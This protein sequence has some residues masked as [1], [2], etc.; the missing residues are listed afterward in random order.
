MTHFWKSCLLLLFVTTGQLSAQQKIKISS[1]NH[2]LRDFINKDYS[3]TLYTYQDEH[4]LKMDHNAFWAKLGSEAYALRVIS[5]KGKQT[6]KQLEPRPHHK[7]I[8][9][10]VNFDSL[11]YSLITK[12]AKDYKGK[13]VALMIFWAA[14]SGCMMLTEDVK[15]IEKDY[16]D[17]VFV[18][19]T[20]NWKGLK[21]YGEKHQVG[22]IIILP[23]TYDADVV[24]YYHSGA[25]NTLFIDENSEIKAITTGARLDFIMKA[26][27]E[28]LQKL[29]K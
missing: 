7:L 14:S 17:I 26:F 10:K 6:I 5:E 24:K 28:K 18:H 19:L 1:G 9:T 29:Q 8:G 15:L 13:K 2:S 20:T 16:P 25:P 21:A 11:D 12:T 23:E 22:D 4:G 27:K 3:D